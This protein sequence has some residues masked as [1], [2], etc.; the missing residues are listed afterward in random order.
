[1]VIEDSDEVIFGFY[2]PPE[3]EVVQR[4]QAALSQ[5]MGR[6]AVLSSYNFTT[7]GRHFV[8]YNI[9]VVGYAP[10]DEVQAHTAGERIAIAEI[11][12]S[13]RGHMQLLRE[14]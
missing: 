7:D 10:G 13:L 5:G 9:P 8:P 12:E 4:A 6:P 3:S 11:E 14:F 1:M 2:T